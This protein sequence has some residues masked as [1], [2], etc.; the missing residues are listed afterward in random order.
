MELDEDVEVNLFVN[1]T[2]SS[3]GAEPLTF[4][5]YCKE[6]FEF[7]AEGEDTESGYLFEVVEDQTVNIVME[8]DVESW[9]AGVDIASGKTTDGKIIISKQSNIT[10]YNAII[11]NI[12]EE[13]LVVYNAE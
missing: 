10:L 4:E 3:A 8:F 7:E 12:D 6:D 9:F 1:G 11:K 13:K 5:F 2:L